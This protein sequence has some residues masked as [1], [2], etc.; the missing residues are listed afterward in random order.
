MIS[1]TR[2]AFR[3]FLLATEISVLAFA[4]LTAHL[5][6]KASIRRVVLVASS[7]SLLY[8]AVQMGLEFGHPD[9]AFK[10]RNY[11]LQITAK[12]L[13]FNPG[14]PPSPKLDQAFLYAFEKT[15]P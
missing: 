2:L 14:Q 6:S 15:Q 4:L 11:T 7:A 5:D 3:A 1:W 10:V 8:S 13:N 12:R 9:T